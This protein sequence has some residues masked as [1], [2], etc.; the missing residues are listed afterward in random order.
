MSGAAPTAAR[1]SKCKSSEAQGGFVLPRK[2]KLEEHHLRSLAL[3]LQSS[4][5]FE[6]GVPPAVGERRKFEALE[7]PAAGTRVCKTIPPLARLCPHL[8]M[9]Q[10][11]HRVPR[12]HG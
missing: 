11:A 4:Q 9:N 12:R 7:P 1:H 5:P 3:C 6:F 10:R 2:L 8:L